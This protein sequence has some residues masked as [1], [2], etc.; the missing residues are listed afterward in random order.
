M[1]HQDIYS[2]CKLVQLL[3]SKYN[4]I[5]IHID[6]KWK[7][8]NKQEILS[9]PHVSDIY[10]YQKYR[11]YWG[12][13]IQ[14]KC[15]LFLLEK[16]IKK[17]S[18][19]YYHLLSGSDLPIKTQNEILYFFDKNKGREFIHFDLYEPNREKE[20]KQYFLFYS[21][22][23][24]N[25]GIKKK[26][27]KKCEEISLIFQDIFHI[28]R[29]KHFAYGAN[30]FSITDSLARSLI[31]DKTWLL[32]FCQF[33]KNADELLL[34]TY[35]VNKGLEEK[36][37]MFGP[38]NDYHANMRCIDWNRGKPYVY[39]IEDLDILLQSDYLF[40][41]KFSAYKDKEVIDKIYEMF[42]NK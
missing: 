32:R 21:L 19:D 14:A 31:K 1:A 40:A 35:I 25:S 28:K 6:K 13:I 3:D 17:D 30:W 24:K 26:I 5:F 16:A 39:T 42:Y 8:F 29:N 22:I 38:Y 23:Q 9:L 15:E 33:T 41:R 10:I 7:N 2:L 11:V 27:W 34:Q 18:Y 37:F 4:T 20:L 36:C 12:S